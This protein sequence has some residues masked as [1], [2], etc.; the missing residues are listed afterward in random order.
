MV[1]NVAVETQAAKPSV[2]QIEV[3]FLTQ[4]PLGANAE[5]VV[6][7]Q[8]PDHQLRI[9]RGA[10]DIAVKKSKM[11]PDVRK[12]DEP[13]DLA[14]D[15]IDGNMPLQA[16]A[17]EQFLLHRPPFAHHRESPRFIAKTES[18]PSRRRKRVFQHNPPWPT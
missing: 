8:H 18:E 12:I 6:D 17:I 2:G 10:S 15:V 11:R 16:K 7:D 5:A 13:V 1:G 14:Q 9:D 3:N 4:P